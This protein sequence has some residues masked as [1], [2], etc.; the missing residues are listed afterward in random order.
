MDAFF[1]LLNK[2]SI[3]AL[4]IIL[5]FC[6][7][8]LN[9]VEES[10]SKNVT[11]FTL[12]ISLPILAIQSLQMEYT[13]DTIFQGLYIFLIS[14]GIYLLGYAIGLIGIKIFKIP[15]EKKGAWLFGLMMSNV[16]FMGMPV[17]LAIYGQEVMFYF[18]FVCIASN[19]FTYIFGA[20][21]IASNA[22][23]DKE[24]LNIKELIF[25]PL[26]F[27]MAIGLILFIFKI[28]LPPIIMETSQY[29]TSTVVP[30]AMFYVGV[31]LAKNSIKEMVGDWQVYAFALTRL[32]II[33]LFAYFIVRNFVSDPM[34][35]ATIVIP[36]SAMSSPSVTAI[37]VNKYGGDV[38]FAARITFIST[39]LCGLT[40][41]IIG[42]LML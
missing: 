38:K 1:T 10:F 16:V 15:G 40:M 32:I 30:L 39:V 8:K 12:K 19:I 31:N 5:G 13:N 24:S 6:A 41:P 34:I 2:T 35:L 22:N 3:L 14:S 26:N 25:T 20:W 37:L 11:D 18:T 42:S 7:K 29:I 9:W 28:E 36:S 21:I 33:P 4:L 17:M 23:A 27:G